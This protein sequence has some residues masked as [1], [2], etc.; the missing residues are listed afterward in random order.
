LILEDLE[1]AIK[2][3]AKI[4][5]EVVGYGCTSDAYHVTAPDPE[6]GG[7]ARTMTMALNDAEIKP[8][9]IDYI[10]AH[11]TSTPLNDKFETLAIKKIFGE[12]AYNIHI[13]STKS[14]T[15]HMLGATGAIEAIFTILTIK[16]S[17]I[18]PTINYETKDEECDLNYTPN[19]GILGEIRYAL[20]NSF[21][22]GGTNGSLIFKKFEEK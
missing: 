22:F 7:A 1:H 4:Y 17:F 12:N 18:P 16:D 13:S 9:E 19:K 11:G 20:S 21:G 10:N 2:R 8:E 3:G 15:G 5:A 14:M 6:G